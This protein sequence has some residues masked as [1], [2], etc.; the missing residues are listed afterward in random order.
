MKSKLLSSKT[1]QSMLIVY[2]LI[3]AGL[4]F[5]VQAHTAAAATGAS[6]D[7]VTVGLQNDMVNMNIWDPATNSVWKQYQTEFNYEGLQ[8]H[9]PDFSSYPVLEDPAKGGANCPAGSLPSRPGYCIDAAGT[10]VTVYIRNNITFTDGTPLNADDVI[11]S[12]QVSAPWSVYSTSILNAIWWDAPKYPLWNST[13]NGGTCAGAKCVSHVG[14]TKS[15]QFTVTFHLAKTYALFFYDTMEVPI[16]PAH[17]WKNHMGTWPQLNLSNPVGNL[18]DSFDNA[19]SFG[20]GAAG[21]TDASMGTGPFHISAWTHNTGATIDI[22]TSYWGKGQTHVWKSKTYPF[23]PFAVRHIATKIYGSLDVVSLALQK[24]DID[25]MVWPVTP[26]FL[27]QIRTNPAISVEQV[28]DSGFFYLSFNLRREPWGNPSYGK[29]LRTAVSMAINKDYIV[30]TLMGGFGVKG[31]VPISIANPLYVNTSAQPPGFDPTLGRSNLLAAGFKDCNGDGF[32]ETP[33]CAPI[34]ATILT[35]PKDYDPIRADAGIMISNNLKSMGLDI[36]AAPTSFDTIVAKAFSAPVN[37]DIYILGFSLGDFPE[38]YICAF[39]CT[40]QDVNLNT[41]GSNSAGYSNARVDSLITS[42]LTDTDTA[43]RVQKLKDVEGILTTELPW[44][45]LYYRQNLVAYRNDAWVGWANY[46]NGGGIWNI[47]SI[48]YIRHSIAPPPPVAGALTIALGMPDQV[49]ARQDVAINVFVSQANARLTGASVT[50]NISYGSTY[51]VQNGVTDATGLAS[52]TW[53][54][55][56]IQGNALASVTVTKGTVSG[57]ASKIMEVTVAPPAPIVQLSLSSATPV[58]RPTEKATITAT[59]IDATGAPVSGKTVTIDPLLVLG[60]LDRNNNTTDA[61]GKANFLYTPPAISKFTNQHHA[62]V[63]KAS[64]NIPNTIVADT[65]KASM[66]LFVQN[67]LTPNWMILSTTPTSAN[68]LVLSPGASSG[69]ACAQPPVPLA[70]AGNF[71][72]LAFSTVTSTGPTIVTGDLGLSPGTSV[73]GFPPGTVVGTIHAGDPVAAGAQLNL[74]AAYNNALSRTVCPSTVAGDL[75]GRTLTPGTYTSSSSLAI[76]TADLTLNAQGNPGAVFVFR[77]ASTLTVGPARHVILTGGAQ[78]S[79]VFWQVGSSATFDTTSV[80]VGTVMAFASISMNTGAT[81]NGRALARG[82]AVTLLSNL[83]TMPAASGTGGAQSANF[84]V[85]LTNWTGAAVPNI[86]IDPQYTD[87]ANVSVVASTAGSNVTDANGTAKFTVTETAS[88]IAGS[89]NT[90][91]GLRFVA[92]NQVFA[93]SDMLELLVSSGANTTGY[94]AWVTFDARTMAFNPAG[95]KNNVTAHVVNQLGAAANGVPVFFQI[96]YGNLGL[97][98]EFTWTM[99]YATPQYLGAGLDLNSFAS[100]NLGGSFQN[101]SGQGPGYGVE[102]FIEDFEVI[103]DVPNLS[104][105]ATIDSCAP[106][107]YPA[108]F[109]GHYYINATSKTGVQGTYT[110]EFTAMPHRIDNPIQVRAYIGGTPDLKIDACAFTSAPEKFAFRVDSGLVSQRAPVFGLSSLTTSRP[111]FSSQTLSATITAV[112]KGVG[113]LPA[114]TAEV[115]L[116]AGAGSAARNVK[117]AFGGT[118]HANAAGYL[119][120]TRTVA[121]AS[122]SQPLAFS[123]IPADFRYAYGGRDQLFAGDFGDYWFAPTFAALLAKIPFD[124]T[125]GYL[126]LPTSTAFLTSS[127]NKVLLAPGEAA[128]LTVNV[129]SILTGLPIVGAT[130]WS[131]GTQNVT[132]ATGVATLPVTGTGQGAVETLVVATTPYGG[133]ARGWFGYIVSAPVLSYSALSVTPATAGVAATITAT[134]TN[135]VAV[136]GQVTVWLY[137]DN[138]SVAA[139]VLNMTAAGTAGGT[140]TVTFTWT[141]TQGSHTVMIGDQSTTITVAPATTGTTDQTGTYVLAGGLLVAGLVVGA[142]AGTLMGRRG[143]RPPRT[144]TTTKTPGGGTKTEEELPPEL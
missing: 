69:G 71:A 41:G 19:I 67:D 58:I 88:A 141:F 127:L 48:P 99:D 139:Q 134:V 65:Q 26:G 115:I 57:A 103:N 109:D 84:T 128:T 107:T 105:G 55:P 111:I 12:F 66:I 113:G 33:T 98:A 89:V 2:V 1:V 31:T 30:N 49:Y 27:S 79:N 62:E 53:T 129:R 43:S 28:T 102:N 130:V 16:G 11:F 97:P 20:Y 45:V 91:V 110:A 112:F 40:S 47:W 86:E 54:V 133:A 68:G 121:L 123:F 14:I 118:M 39:F 116:T 104:T 96:D 73:T 29:A 7:T 144:V 17:I 15:D 42:A 38:T 131:G 60:T 36:D 117:G 82:A 142:V 21:Q 90:N 72:V 93:T 59:L 124:F 9:D 6:A 61:N 95:A 35:P 100:G 75:G 78:A 77:M 4:L 81:M 24:G 3:G 64:V 37:F 46:P 137:V 122:L 32:L 114:P 87:T 135:T 51:F 56:V 132:N 52:F 10:G 18:I 80:M 101:S 83:V 106:S 22:Y 25:T 125:R 140:Q 108:G 5:V 34:K 120:Y 8:S 50:L 94:A 76:T 63:I 143:R 126:Y 74:T 92:K 138:K 85:T 119:N 136:A 44:N 70:S 13:A 23:Y